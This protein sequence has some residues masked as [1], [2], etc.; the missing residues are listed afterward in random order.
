MRKFTAWREK[1]TN[2]NK[3]VS[4]PTASESLVAA[5][6]AYEKSKQAVDAVKLIAIMEGAKAF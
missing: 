5:K 4:I 3:G 1:K 6:L 2:G